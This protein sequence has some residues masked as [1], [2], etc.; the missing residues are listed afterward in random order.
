MLLRGMQLGSDCMVVSVSGRATPADVVLLEQL[1]VRS[2]D[3]GPTLMTDLVGIVQEMR[4]A[5]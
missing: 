1:G 2:L 3:K 4:P 5:R